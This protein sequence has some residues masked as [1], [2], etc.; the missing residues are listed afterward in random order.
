[1]PMM[2]TAVGGTCFL[3]KIYTAVGKHS[4]VLHPYLGL[5]EKRYTYF[6]WSS[7]PR[8][9]KTVIVPITITAAT[10][11]S[12]ARGPPDSDSPALRN[13]ATLFRRTHRG[14][15]CGGRKPSVAL[16]IAEAV[17]RWERGMFAPRLSLRSTGCTWA[18]CCSPGRFLNPPASG[19]PRR[20]C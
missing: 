6:R 2:Y 5:S 13:E 1:M 14:C 19:G 3:E 4:T 18:K 7:K 15:A 17:S 10:P 12:I 20:E 8:R 9:D 11:S 16:G